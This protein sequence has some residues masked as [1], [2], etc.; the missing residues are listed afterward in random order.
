MRIII[1]LLVWFARFRFFLG[2]F[3]L[4]LWAFFWCH[5]YLLA[6]PDNSYSIFFLR[7]TEKLMS[8]G[9]LTAK[10]LRGYVLFRIGFVEIILV[11]LCTNKFKYT[12]ETFQDCVYVCVTF[13]VMFIYWI[14]YGSVE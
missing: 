1:Y 12:M 4:V 5:N 9:S 6:A 10:K 14:N 3:T 11:V 8:G 2:V 7:L 13:I